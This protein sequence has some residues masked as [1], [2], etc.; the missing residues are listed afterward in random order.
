MCVCLF[1]C[2][3]VCV[4]VCLCVCLFRRFFGLVSSDITINILI[5]IINK[6]HKLLTI[7]HTI[8]LLYPNYIPTS[9]ISL[10]HIYLKYISYYTR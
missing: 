10:M 2:A 9:T 5:T 8:Y 3:C 6:Q 4:L 1:V 7:L